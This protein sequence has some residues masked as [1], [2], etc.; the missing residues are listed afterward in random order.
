METPFK[1]LAD[2]GDGKPIPAILTPLF[3]PMRAP[4]LGAIPL[5]R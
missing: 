4:L 2:A 1:N 3:P 5:T